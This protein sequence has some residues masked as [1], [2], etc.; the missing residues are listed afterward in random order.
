MPETVST[1]TRNQGNGRAV[2]IYL[3]L[4]LIFRCNYGGGAMPLGPSVEAEHN[5]QLKAHIT[6][7]I[8]YTYATRDG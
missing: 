7:E 5:P 3:V 4:P 1:I 8:A 6:N 2:T